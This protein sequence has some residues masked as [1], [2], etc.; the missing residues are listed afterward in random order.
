MNLGIRNNNPTNIRYAER[1]DWNGQ[2]GE[3]KGFCVF[4]HPKYGIR[5]A[6]KT[7]RSY[8]KRGVET[9]EE[10]ITT[11]APPHENDT[12]NYVA[13]VEKQ[14]GIDAGAVV[15]ESDYYELLKAMCKMESGFKLTPELW[16]EVQEVL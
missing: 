9:L 3:H 16:Q 14:T 12:L 11:W 8:A 13:F 4:S 1:N 15:F 10:I 2:T 7:L 5:A 6:V